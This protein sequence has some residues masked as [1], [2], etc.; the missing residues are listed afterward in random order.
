MAL[1]AIAKAQG[2]RGLAAAARRWIATEAP[3]AYR[4]ALYRRVATGVLWSVENERSKESPGG[5]GADVP[6]VTR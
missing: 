4:S 2:R 1:G 3:E 5:P 6:P